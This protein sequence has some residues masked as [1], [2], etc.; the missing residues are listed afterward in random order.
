MFIQ[1]LVDVFLFQL[2]TNCD[3]FAL[4]LL[5]ICQ[6]FFIFLHYI[7]K[8]TWTQN[9][10]TSKF[11]NCIPIPM[12]LCISKEYFEALG[13]QLAG[14]SVETIDKLCQ[15]TNADS[16]NYFCYAGTKTL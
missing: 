13:L 4:R 9:G 16:L 5:R 14:Y 10:F 8:K 3:T 1:S 6:V 7:L 11:K 12:V 15:A 2:Q